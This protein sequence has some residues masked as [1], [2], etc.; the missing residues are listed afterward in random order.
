M[1]DERTVASLVQA[2]R[3]GEQTAWDAIVDRFLPLVASIASRHGL[4]R[5]DSDDV[6]QTVWLRLVESLDD[7]R[8]PAAL[9]GWIATTTRNECFRLLRLR[10]R[11][12]LVDPLEPSLLDGRATSDDVTSDLEAAERH[13]AL[14]EA[15]LELPA[16]RRELLVMMLGDPPPSYGEI[17]TRLGIPVGS[18]G[19]T[20]ARALAQLRRTASI[21]ALSAT[22][23]ALDERGR[24]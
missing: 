5:S 2:A 20:R 6:N 21:R 23:L 22:E 3:S 13:H 10:G 1:E 16:D 4:S 17:S 24:Q 15:L 7:I 19:P 14:R 8:Q 9:A 11:T 18:I 12:I